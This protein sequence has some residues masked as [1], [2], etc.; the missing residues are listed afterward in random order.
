MKETDKEYYDRRGREERY[1]SR[2]ANSSAS[3]TIHGELADLCHERAHGSAN[4]NGKT[5]I[6]VRSR[7]ADRGTA[8]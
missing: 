5:G 3:R 2:S 7:L 4:V 1:R 8:T 6:R